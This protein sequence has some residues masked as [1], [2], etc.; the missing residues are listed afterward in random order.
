[1]QARVHL[2]QPDGLHDDIALGGLDARVHLEQLDLGERVVVLAPVAGRRIEDRD[3][4]DGK[5]R[6][7][8]GRR[9]RG[10]LV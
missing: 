1:M 6:P 9:R 8:R 4:G 3:G 10:F 7:R 5:R 2:V